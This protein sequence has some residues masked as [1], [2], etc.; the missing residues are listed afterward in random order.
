MTEY[1][2]KYYINSFKVGITKAEF[3]H[4]LG[5][6]EGHGRVVFDILDKY[7]GS[8]NCTVLEAAL[9]WIDIHF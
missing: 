1:P 6:G 8:I 2:A 7:G 9:F 3:H 5:G 4:A